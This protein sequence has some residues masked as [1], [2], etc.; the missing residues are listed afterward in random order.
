M[1]ALRKIANDR[2]L[3]DA[4]WIHG[5][6]AARQSLARIEEIMADSRAMEAIEG[7]P[8]QPAEVPGSGGD[9]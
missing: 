4:N 1:S 9:L 2:E 5:G 6:V 3:L 8:I 7:G